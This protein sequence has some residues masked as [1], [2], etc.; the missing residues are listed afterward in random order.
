M[1]AEAAAADKVQLTTE[2]AS[3]HYRYVI[4]QTE[5]VIFSHHCDITN[6]ISP[7]CDFVVITGQDFTSKNI[8]IK[9]HNKVR[10]WTDVLHI[11]CGD[12]YVMS[13]VSIPELEPKTISVFKISPTTGKGMCHPK[14]DRNC[15]YHYD[16]LESGDNGEEVRVVEVEH[17]LYQPA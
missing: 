7:V 14:Q 12:Y 11:D 10:L 15:I 5:N 2:Q 13:D 17:T 1:T 8:V 4:A 16:L 9:D 6:F 3:N